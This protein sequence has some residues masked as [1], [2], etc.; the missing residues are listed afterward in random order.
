MQVNLSPTWYVPT[1]PR[2]LMDWPD[3]TGLIEQ[4][5]NVTHEFKMI[6]VKNEH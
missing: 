3:D 6:K 4:L 1:Y 5:I 2:F